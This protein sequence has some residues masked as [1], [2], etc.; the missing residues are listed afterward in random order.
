ML[1]HVA[2]GDPAAF[3]DHRHN[4]G[5]LLKFLEYHLYLNRGASGA[6]RK[7][8][9]SKTT[10]NAATTAT[11]TPPAEKPAQFTSST[12]SG[13]IVEVTNVDFNVPIGTAV[14]AS[15]SSGVDRIVE[16]YPEVRMR[17]RLGAR[18]FF[19]RHELVDIIE[20]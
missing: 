1:L 6:P 7:A 8:V 16:I 3:G 13:F 11:A 18:S 5:I 20:G 10:G 19:V 2:V 9:V 17:F 15:V 14:P 4:K 12:F